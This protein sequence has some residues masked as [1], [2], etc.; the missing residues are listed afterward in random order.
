MIAKIARQWLK[1]Q[2]NAKAL[3]LSQLLGSLKSLDI[4]LFLIRFY[5]EQSEN[6]PQRIFLRR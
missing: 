4:Y 1:P 3:S 6:L 2:T 5:A